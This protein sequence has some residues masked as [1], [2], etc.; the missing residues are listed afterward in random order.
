MELKAKHDAIKMLAGKLK[1]KRE[2]AAREAAIEKA[3]EDKI[4][5]L[6]EEQKKTLARSE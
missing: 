4:N 3:T 1:S 2:W 5:K 6:L